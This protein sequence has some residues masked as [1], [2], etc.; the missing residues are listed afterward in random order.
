V[1]LLWGARWFPKDRDSTPRMLQT[2][3]CSQQI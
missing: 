2:K 3:Y 1:T